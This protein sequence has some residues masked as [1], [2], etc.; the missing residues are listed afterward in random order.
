MMENTKGSQQ[1]VFNTS[2]KTCFCSS[3]IIIYFVYCNTFFTIIFLYFHILYFIVPDIEK[4]HK[5]CFRQDK[6]CRIS[7]RISMKLISIKEKEPVR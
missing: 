3:V 1:T 2:T 6:P 5:I 4:T 7:K